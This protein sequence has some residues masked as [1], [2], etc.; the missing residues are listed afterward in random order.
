MNRPQ[1]VGAARPG[2][3]GIHGKTRP[4]ASELFLTPPRPENLRKD[5]ADRRRPGHGTVS[6]RLSPGNSGVPVAGLMPLGWFTAPPTL[7][8]PCP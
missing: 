6:S 1:S 4:D 2:K 8:P 3:A 5:A 7:D